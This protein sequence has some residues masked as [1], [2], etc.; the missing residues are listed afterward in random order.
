MGTDDQTK[1]LGT[2]TGTSDQ[3]NQNQSGINMGTSEQANNQPGLPLC[4]GVPHVVAF[5]W[6]YNQLISLYVIF[7]RISS[8]VYLQSYFVEFTIYI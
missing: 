5:T 3:A 6:S 4:H 8:G 1:Q 7:L 2:K